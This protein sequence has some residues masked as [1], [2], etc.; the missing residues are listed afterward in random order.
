[1]GVSMALLLILSH[2]V[3]LPRIYQLSSVCTGV[4]CPSGVRLYSMPNNPLRVFWRLSGSLSNYTVD[5]QGSSGN[6]TC[7]PPPGGNYCD[8]TDVTCGSVYTV[9]VVPVNMDGSTVSFCP[10]RLYSG[11]VYK[12]A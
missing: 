6:Y 3:P 4:C 1:M 2:L 5:V 7:S 9:V 11:T 8:L 12:M 10:H